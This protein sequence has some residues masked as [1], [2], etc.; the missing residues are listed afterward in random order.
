MEPPSADILTFAA[1]Q[2]SVQVPATTAPAGDSKDHLTLAES[3]PESPTVM[4]GVSKYCIHS[5]KYPPSGPIDS[6]AHQ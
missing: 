6:S 5:S 3:I 1:S 2:P 4:E